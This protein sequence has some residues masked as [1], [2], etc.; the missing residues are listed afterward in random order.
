[1]YYI[2]RTTPLY[3]DCEIVIYTHKT[4]SQTRPVLLSSKKAKDE[5]M[6]AGN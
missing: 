5:A 3:T 2:Y 6:V 4:R 1:M